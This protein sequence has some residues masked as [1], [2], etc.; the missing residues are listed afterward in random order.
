MKARVSR[1]VGSNGAN[2]WRADDPVPTKHAPVIV[3]A[4]SFLIADVEFVLGGQNKHDGWA[5]GDV[6]SAAD[7]GSCK[8]PSFAITDPALTRLDNDMIEELS[9]EGWVPFRFV[10]GTGFVTLPGQRVLRGARLVLLGP[11]FASLLDPAY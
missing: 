2:E 7:M 11:K 9:E 6:I 5:V 3:Y 8:G 10:R 1:N 4:R